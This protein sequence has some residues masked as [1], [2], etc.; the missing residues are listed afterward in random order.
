[1]D[2]TGQLKELL[3]PILKECGVRLYDLK[4]TGGSEHTLE[5]S[6]MHEDGSMDL[7]TCAEVS[8]KL[9]DFL[10]AKDIIK[11]A[12]TLE[13]CSPGAEREIRDLKELETMHEPY[14]FMRLK[15]PFKKLME[16]TGTVKSY[17]D[18]VI[19]LEYREKAA[20]RKAEIPAADIEKIR[21]A[22]KF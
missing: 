17:S 9:S 14:V 13:V 1:M 20:V 10:D 3:E 15:H 7:D 19:I 12:Y 8:T 2:N 18:G 11:S 21:L 16:L 22:I 5:V 4:W 6:I